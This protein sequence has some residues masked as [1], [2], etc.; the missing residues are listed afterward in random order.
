[1]PAAVCCIWIVDPHFFK[2]GEQMF[3]Q[4]KIWRSIY[5]DFA[6]F[7]ESDLGDETCHAHEVYTEERLHA[8]AEQG[9][10]GIWVHAL[11]SHIAQADPFPELSPH[12][13]IHQ[14]RLRILIRR[15]A[16]YGIK[17]FLYIQPLRAV[18]WSEEK[19]WRKYKAD[20]G[21]TEYPAQKE[22]CLCISTEPVK[23]W[24]ES[25]SEEMARKLPELGGVLLITASELPGHCYS[26]RQRKGEQWGIECPR[27][28]ERGPEEIVADQ[29]VAVRNGIRKAS[30]GMEVIVWTWSWSL[31]RFQP[32]WHEISDRLPADIAILTDFERGGHQDFWHRQDHC[33]NEYCLSY[34]GPSETCRAM[35]QYARSRGMKRLVKLQLGTTHELASVVSLPLLTNVAKKILAC[36]EL[37]IDGFLGCWNFGSFPSANTAAAQFLL[38]CPL[39]PGKDPLKLFVKQYFGPDC[40]ADAV[41]RA[42]AGFAEA[43]YHFP[44]SNVF[45]YNAPTNYALAYYEVYRPGPLEGKPCGPS[46]LDIPDRGD[47]LAGSFDWKSSGLQE[48]DVYSLPEIL[49][50]LPHLCSAWTECVRALKA[51]FGPSGGKSAELEINN[52]ELIGIIWQSLLHAFRSYA[53]RQAWDESKRPRLHQIIR[54]EMDLIPT[55]IPLLMKDPRQGW[56]GE[57]AAYLFSPEKI[58]KKLTVLKS[59]LQC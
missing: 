46:H 34:A 15:A 32:P 43:M 7:P 54:E 55:A 28:S 40:D 45:I 37:N 48:K 27:C 13:E 25:L 11:L 50:T 36:R 51:A 56:H 30:A 41:I 16:K 8:I 31:W 20:L 23:K 2:Q 12:A 57:A 14:K 53:V 42:Y 9:F 26:H 49:E 47:S 5:S 17:V 4:Y 33:I 6:P 18:P 21:G 39:E 24:I 35:L 44:F 1:M 19:F 29:L 58:G 59:Y 10:N 22:R 38:S 3:C 52:A